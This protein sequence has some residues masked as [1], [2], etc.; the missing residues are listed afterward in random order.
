MKAPASRRV[1]LTSQ[2]PP[3]R[4][5]FIEFYIN[6]RISRSFASLFLV[7]SRSAQAFG[8][9]V[10]KTERGQ[11]APPAVGRVW[12]IL[13]GKRSSPPRRVHK[14][15]DRAGQGLSNGV[16]V[17]WIPV[18]ISELWILK[19]PQ[20]EAWNERHLPSPAFEGPW[21]ADASSDRN[22]LN[23]LSIEDF[24]GYRMVY[25]LMKFN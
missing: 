22:G 19:D 5:D 13:A 8:R 15:F 16:N 21:R 3:Y 2:V 23:R 4:A 11:S 7:A 18:I 24:T 14:T 6:R 12:T 9:K 10:A 20:L 25:N 17:D 1:E